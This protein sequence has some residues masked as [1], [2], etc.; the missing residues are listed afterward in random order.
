LRELAHEPDVPPI[1]YARE[2]VKLGQAWAVANDTAKAEPMVRQGLKT[3]EAKLPADHPDVL[4]A[5]MTLAD[6][7]TW[8]LNRPD[9]AVTIL[10][11]V[12]ARQKRL[13][14]ERSSSVAVSLTALGQA[15]WQM[16]RLDDAVAATQSAC[17][18]MRGIYT[19]PHQD[20][21]K[22][23]STLGNLYEEMGG[24]LDLAA[25]QFAEAARIAAA[26]D[27]ENG[28]DALKLRG[29][30]GR[31]RALQGR[32]DEAEGM[33]A[34]IYRAVDVQSPDFA[35]LVI[36]YA[37][38]LH[39]QHRDAE[40]S[41]ALDRIEPVLKKYPDMLHDETVDTAKLRKAIVATR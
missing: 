19:R 35:K 2:L 14:G 33:L 40:A 27:G 22:C 36:D 5:R 1:D 41:A 39:R 8:N 10:Q 20:S 18:I 15:Y 28:S 34:P 6:L 31:I 11:D 23:L 25:D 17:D 30:L 12:I 38:V 13:Y 3:L 29:E 24:K 32:L 21:L 4:R 16:H 7:L 9:E 37:D 26:L